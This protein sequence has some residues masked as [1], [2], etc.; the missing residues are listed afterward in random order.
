MADMARRKGGDLNDCL[1]A[2]AQDSKTRNRRP[3]IIWHVR[4]DARDYALWLHSMYAFLSSD[5]SPTDHHSSSPLLFEY[6]VC[7]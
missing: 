2:D 3:M 6:G 7:T 5:F 4:G 1:D